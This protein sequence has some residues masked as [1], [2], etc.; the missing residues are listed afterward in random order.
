MQRVRA[1]AGNTRP[2]NYF[3]AGMMGCSD[4]RFIVEAVDAAVCG[5][6][7]VDGWR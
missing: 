5:H 3:P 2:I 6:R 4:A 7:G 1:Q